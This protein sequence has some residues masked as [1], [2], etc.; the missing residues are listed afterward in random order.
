[1]I[2]SIRSHAPVAAFGLSLTAIYVVALS[3]VALPNLRKYEDQARFG[4]I[5]SVAAVV[6][7]LCGAVFSF[8]KY[9]HQLRAISYGELGMFKPALLAC[10][11]LA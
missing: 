8:G 4:L 10:I 7:L 11:G 3:I 2:Q 6:P 5:A 9:N 1:M